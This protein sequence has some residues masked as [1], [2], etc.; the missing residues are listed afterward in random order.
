MP[1]AIVGVPGIDALI[2]PTSPGAMPVAPRNMRCPFG[3]KSPKRL[4]QTAM[5]ACG[6]TSVPT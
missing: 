4:F 3:Q 1:V 5:T 6:V 2:S